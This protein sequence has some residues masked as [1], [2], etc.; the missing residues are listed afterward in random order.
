MPI[1][2]PPLTG[3]PSAG[4]LLALGAP[5]SLI[6]ELRLIAHRRGVSVASVAVAAIAA[7]CG[8]TTAQA[9]VAIIAGCGMTP[10]VVVPGSPPPVDLLPMPGVE[11][12]EA[13]IEGDL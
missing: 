4:P 13:D 5:D 6:D 2:Y 10:P 7:G 1:G 12:Y 8:Q 3:D 11:V 9:G